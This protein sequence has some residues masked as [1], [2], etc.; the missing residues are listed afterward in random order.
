MTNDATQQPRARQEEENLPKE[1]LADSSSDSP[2][3][4]NNSKDEPRENGPS[5]SD[6]ESTMALEPKKVIDI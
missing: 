6:P 4:D 2:V 1:P 3:E 5:E